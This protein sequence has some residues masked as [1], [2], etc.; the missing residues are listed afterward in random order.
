M[1]AICWEVIAGLAICCYYEGIC[2]I[3]IEG[4]GYPMG[5]AGGI[6]TGDIWGWPG[7]GCWGGIL[8]CCGIYWGIIIGDICCY[9]GNG[10]CCLEMDC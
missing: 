7:M 1:L 6:I 3:P 2:C 8:Y 9:C 10:C 5:D 4:Y